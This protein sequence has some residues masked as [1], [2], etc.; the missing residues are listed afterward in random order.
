MSN[1][2]SI[3]KYTVAGI[4]DVLSCFGI[5]TG[6]AM[7]I[8]NDILDKRSKDAME[9]LLSEF[10]QGN[11]ENIDENEII[12]IIA[13]FQRDA[14]EGVA[15]NNLRLMA[16]VINGMAEKKNLKAP[17]FLRFANIVASLTEDEIH[18]LSIMCE[19]ACKLQ[20]TLDGMKSQ[21]L[22]INNPGKTKLEKE[23][24][25]Y[26]IIQQSLLRTGLLKMNV[27]TESNNIT[28][29]NP[30]NNIAGGTRKNLDFKTESKS[31]TEYKITPLML[32]V[33]EYVPEIKIQNKEV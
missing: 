23:I 1:Q 20:N 32:E 22:L 25:N 24:Q 16:Q 30:P 2:N 13:R 27:I 26:E 7:E 3:K 4:A 6:T 11:F 9:I 28:Q 17:S 15:K 10:R 18:V 5:P 31:I 29:S 8:Y 19:E 21:P 12:S 33:L 14:M